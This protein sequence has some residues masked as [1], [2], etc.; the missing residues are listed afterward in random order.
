MA[1]TGIS[2]R[3]NFIVFTIDRTS[4]YN[5]SLSSDIAV[6]NEGV[7]NGTYNGYEDGIKN[8][9]VLTYQ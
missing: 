6:I 9:C 5:C 2:Q 7:K 1:I 8:V 4:T 3:P